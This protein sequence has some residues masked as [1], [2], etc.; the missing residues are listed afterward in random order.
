MTQF[1]KIWT[2]FLSEMW[3]VISHKFYYAEFESVKSCQ[4]FESAKSCQDF[5]K[6]EVKCSKKGD[7]D[8]IYYAKLMYFFLELIII[9]YFEIKNCV[10][11]VAE[12]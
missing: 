9:N 1:D 11:K 2:F 3:L 10:F 6:I 12:F 4:D 5:E 7:F 8:D